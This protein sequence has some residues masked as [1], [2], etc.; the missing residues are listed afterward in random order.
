MHQGQVIG[1]L[2]GTWVCNHEHKMRP[3][4]MGKV[5]FSPSTFSCQDAGVEELESQL[6]EVKKTE[7]STQ[8]EG[9]SKGV[10]IA[11]DGE[12]GWVGGVVWS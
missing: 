7:K 6:N 10:V 5:F 12:S 3:D 9:M 1:W 8:C 4:S 11:M 2:S